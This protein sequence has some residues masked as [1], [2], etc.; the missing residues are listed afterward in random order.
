MSIDLKK[1]SE[2]NLIDLRKKASISLEKKGLGGQVARVGIVLDISGSMDGLYRRGI[3]QNVAERCLALAMNFDDNGAADVFAFGIRDYEIGEIDQSNFYQFIEREILKKYK[4]E[5]GTQ[6]AGVVKRIADKYYPNAITTTKKSGFLGFGGKTE[7]V[8]DGSRYRNDPPCY[9]FYLTDGDNQDKDEMRAV[10]REV[11]K[12]GIFFQ[13]VGVGR[14]SFKFL[15]E[16]DNLEGRY[17]D[18]ANFFKV[19]NL[20]NISDDQLYDM[21]LAEFPEWLK[22]AK[23]HQIIG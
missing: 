14:D 18:N 7:V 5:A 19:D 21:I 23:S 13:F 4:L 2:E 6:Y 20:D 15:N 17:I 1:K 9:I 3:V 10:M 11:S 16:L 12:L 8:V 22:L